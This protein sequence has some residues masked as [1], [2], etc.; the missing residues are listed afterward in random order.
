MIILQ[1]FLLLWNYIC[2]G[3]VSSLSASSLSFSDQMHAIEKG[4]FK[5]KRKF[6]YLFTVNAYAGFGHSK[7]FIFSVVKTCYFRHNFRAAG[8]IWLLVRGMCCHYKYLFKAFCP[9]HANLSSLRFLLIRYYLKEILGNC[10]GSWL[11]Y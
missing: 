2:H 10:S 4:L 3:A 11:L 1:S 6:L 7:A 5:V 9:Y 8:S